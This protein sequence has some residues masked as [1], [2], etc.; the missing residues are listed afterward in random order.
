MEYR[1][2]VRRQSGVAMFDLKCFLPERS[3]S[4]GGVTVAV[5]FI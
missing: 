5:L 3:V 4:A 1:E 2:V